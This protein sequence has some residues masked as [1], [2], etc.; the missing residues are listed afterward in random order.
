M[1]FSERIGMRSTKVGIQID[2]MDEEL[3]N[4]LWNVLTLFVTGPM[5][6][7]SQ[8]IGESNHKDLIETLWLSFF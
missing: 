2:S 5:K 6:E 1:R 7:N 3:K 8:L 4:G